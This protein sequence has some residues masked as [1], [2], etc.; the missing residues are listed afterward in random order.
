MIKSGYAE[1]YAAAG[2]NRGVSSYS[3]ASTEVKLGEIAEQALEPRYS[4]SY[5]D[6]TTHEAASLSKAVNIIE[7]IRGGYFLY[8]NRTAH[9]LTG[10]SP[11]TGDLVASHFLNIRQLCTTLKKA[12][13]QICRRLTFNPN[14]H[15]LW[16]DF[17]NAI[18]P[19]LE[20]MKADQGIADYDIVQVATN[21]KGTLKAR[22]R[23]VPIE[24]V[25][26]F[27][28]EIRLENSLGETGVS[29]SE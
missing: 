29:V 21:Q 27:D 8:G 12:L 1:W 25:E 24:A 20:N 5:I 16:I 9:A 3:I 11:D 17:C 22:V 28:I 15:V 18:R 19:T 26:D 4:V 13:Y 23:I 2:L 7:R 14:S 10:T 6:P